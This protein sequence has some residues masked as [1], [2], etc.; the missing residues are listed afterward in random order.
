MKGVGALLLL[1]GRAKPKHSTCHPLIPCG[2]NLCVTAG[3]NENQTPLCSYCPGW[4][5]EGVEQPLT[6][7][8]W[9][10][11]TE[12]VENFLL[13]ARIK[14]PIQ[15]SDTTLMGELGHLAITWQR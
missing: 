6:A 1:S 2:E 12:G 5:Q 9:T 11:L 14:V 8:H 3:L 7:S 4:E 13:Q 15:S 10:P